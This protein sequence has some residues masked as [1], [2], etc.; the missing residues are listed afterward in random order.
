MDNIADLNIFFEEKHNETLHDHA[1][2]EEIFL[3]SLPYLKRG[4]SNHYLDQFFTKN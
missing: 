3:E 1:G 2:K 4:D